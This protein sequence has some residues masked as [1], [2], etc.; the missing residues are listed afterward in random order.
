MLKTLK[1]VLLLFAVV[2][3]AALWGQD[4]II[5]LTLIGNANASQSGVNYN[6]TITGTGSVSGFGNA[7]LYGTG[8]I[9]LNTIA[10][11]APITGTFTLIFSDT[12]VLVGTFSI[13]PGIL[14][15]QLGGTIGT[16]GA[17][18]I[19]GGTG[20][21][22]GASGSFSG[23]SGSGTLTSATSTSFQISGT[24][25]L[26]TPSAS[27]P[28]TL[29]Y[30]GSIAHIAAGA[31]WETTFTFVNT[32][33][34]ASQLHLAIFDENGSSLPLPVTFPQSPTTPAAQV[35]T[36]DQTLAAGAVLIIESQGGPTLLLGSAQMTTDGAVTGS[37]IFRNTVSGQEAVVPLETRNPAAFVLPFDNTAG[38]A[39]GLA[40][41]NITSTAAAVKIVITDDSGV[42]NLVTDTVNLSA[43]GHLSFVLT[44]KYALTAQRRGTITIQGP[45]N[46]QISVLGIRATTAG[47]YTSIPPGV[48]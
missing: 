20:K 29:T 12:D 38:L 42:N 15:P 24:G 17:A 19:I 9:D 43:R 7:M 1:L 6:F 11:L 30:G 34:R 21:F 48:K 5:R 26:S 40:I 13:P 37:A 14:I 39:N 18:K 46:G 31:G 16:T 41:S 10:S 47:A 45:A 23:L 8:V 32:G 44:E 3:G 2:P 33:T 35:S 27:S 36:I 22:I 28:G 4:S 25:T